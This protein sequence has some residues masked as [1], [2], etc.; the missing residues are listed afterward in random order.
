MECDIVLRFGGT[1]STVRITSN[2]EGSKDSKDTLTIQVSE[3]AL[4]NL[5]DIDNVAEILAGLNEG[6]RKLI[7]KLL[8]NTKPELSYTQKGL[9]GTDGKVLPL[10]N[11]SFAELKNQY[12]AI[13][14]ELED[15]RG[16]NIVLTNAYT[17]NGSSYRGRVLANGQEFY[18]LTNDDDVKAFAMTE[19]KKNLV[20]TLVEGNTIKDEEDRKD[21]LRGM[22]EAKLLALANS[23]K[24]NKEVSERIKSELG[25]IGVSIQ[26]IALDYLNNKSAYTNLYFEYNGE[27]YQARVLLRDFVGDL[28]LEPV[29]HQDSESPLAAALRGISIYRNEL[30]KASLFK[31]LQEYKPALVEGMSEEKFASLSAKEM[32]ELLNEAFAGDLLLQNFEL[33]ECFPTPEKQE[34]IG[35]NTIKKIFKEKHEGENIKYNDV[36]KTVADAKKYIGD[37]ITI[38]GHEYKLTIHQDGEIVRYYIQKRGLSDSNKIRIKYTG[39]RIEDMFANEGLVGYDTMS[40][41]KA[42]DTSETDSDPV[43]NGKYH[44]SYIF[45]VTKNGQTFY[46]VSRSPIN[47]ES[48]IKDQFSSLRDAKARI[49]SYNFSRTPRSATLAQIKAINEVSTK[50]REVYI[51]DSVTIPYYIS[52]GQVLES[53]DYYLP[54]NIENKLSNNERTLYYEGNIRKIVHFYKNTFAV[55]PEILSKVEEVLDTPEKAGIFLLEM[56]NRR[57]TYEAKVYGSLPKDWEAQMDKVLTK[58]SESNTRQFIVQRS[59]KTPA[60]SQQHD[61]TALPYTVYLQKVTTPF[62]SKVSEKHNPR[63]SLTESLFNLQKIFNEGLF[64][65]TGIEIEVKSSEE[66]SDLKTKDGKLVFPDRDSLK[67]IRGFVFNNTIYVNQDSLKDGANAM[68]HEILHITLGVLRTSGDAGQRDYERIIQKFFE[69]VDDNT[70]A[71]VAEKYPGLAQIDYQE[72]VVV[73]HLARQME[74]KQSLFA[75][76]DKDMSDAVTENFIKLFSKVNLECVKAMNTT[77]RTGYDFN[78]FHDLFTKADLS[79]LEKQRKVSNLIE[80]GIING[81]IEEHC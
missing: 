47:P 1:K 23:L 27:K 76:N 64:K 46:T 4:E 34:K 8:N 81:T 59:Y 6:S 72:E 55:S 31:V 51:P 36:V 54:K 48:Y 32:T 19:M 74:N 79:K 78:S 68:Y 63:K 37:T 18:I 61:S 20:N 28:N 7:I 35:I 25:D 66:L 75:I 69:G 58:I 30:G 77:G 10:S 5:K 45:E 67:Y 43:V 80:S 44:G 17:L 11:C 41:F 39:I 33:E 21:Y 50:D 73:R 15:T 62:E 16:Y 56:A 9:L 52:S 22:Y 53:L 42:V 71:Y 3:E 13:L 57:I 26:S 29:L 24:D 49:I 60:L 40:A 38:D 70:K 2:P 14:S 12:P 65:G